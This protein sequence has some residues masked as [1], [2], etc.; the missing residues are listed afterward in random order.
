VQYFWA[1]AVACLILA[2]VRWRKLALVAFALAATN[3]LLIV[4]LYFGPAPRADVGRP[5]RAMSFNVYYLNRDHGAT[6]ELILTELPDFVLLL[7]VTP[8]WAKALEFLKPDYPYQ[9]VIT[10]E[11]SGGMAFYSRHKITHLRVVPLPSIIVGLETPAGPVTIVGAHPPSP[12]SAQQ[13]ERRNFQLAKVGQMAR[14]VAGA[15]VMLGDLNTTSWS[16]YFRDL[17]EGSG[18]RDSR[19]GFG[20]EPSWPWFGWS[21]LRIPIDH[22]LVSP[23]VSVLD[24]QIGPAVGSDHRPLIVE[25]AVPKP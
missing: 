11:D 24:R 12:R 22:C 2:V 4:P 3:L 18:L 7:E 23:E 16:P 1:L 9:H 13:F 6:L 17:L 21:L 25:F 15:V 19:R 8:E 10:R 5:L 14:D 20:V